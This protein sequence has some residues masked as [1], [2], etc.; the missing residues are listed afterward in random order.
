MVKTL[1]IRQGEWISNLSSFITGLAL[2]VGMAT[3]PISAAQAMDVLK[4]GVVGSM[5]GGGAA[6]GMAC[7]Y[8]AK[9][10]A[11]E[12]NAQGGLD[13]GGKKYHVDVISYDDQFKASD[14]VAAYNRLVNLDGVKF[15][16]LQTSNGAMAT[17]ESVEADKSIALTAGFGGKVIE[18]GYRHL[19]RFYSGPRDYMPAFIKWIAQNVP[20][21]T[22]VQ[23]NP[24]IEGG[25]EAAELAAKEYEANGIKVLSSGMFELTQK[26][27]NPV[28]TKAISENPD[29]IDL[30]STSPATAGLIVRQLRDLGYKGKLVKTAGP[31][32]EQIVA[33]A[34]KE[35]SEGL[36]GLMFADPSNP[37]YQH[38]VAAYKKEVG[39]EPNEMILPAYD[40]I[41][42]MLKAIQHAGT[43][44]DTDKVLAAMRKVV[45]MPS[46]Q[47]DELVIGGMDTY[48]A[49]QQI[50][51]YN[52]VGEIRDG[53]SVAVGKIR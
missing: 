8:G 33:G 45:P 6:W 12:V 16:I 27:F 39:Q 17:K 3:A 19:F 21:K 10:A 24:N 11:D 44:E 42:L 2:C 40:G 36:I 53:K 37:G 20:G 41:R 38:I 52:Y 4:I 15:M 5:T 49:D 34:G 1:G 51:T 46:A 18:P 35:V 47:G 31:G 14:T 9:I 32:A 43:I 26:D 13:V 48:G 29:I 23:L 7:Q 22:L 25:Y 30:G 28:L 50:I